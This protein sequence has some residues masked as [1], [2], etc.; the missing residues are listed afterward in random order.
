MGSSP[1]RNGFSPRMSEM[2]FNHSSTR[3]KV[4]SSHVKLSHFWNY[5]RRTYPFVIHS[6]SLRWYDTS[7]LHPK[8]SVS[9]AWKSTQL[10][11]DQLWRRLRSLM[12]RL[13][14][15][16]DNLWSPPPSP[17]TPCVGG[18][19]GLSELRWCLLARMRYAS[20]L[21]QNGEVD[22]CGSWA[23]AWTGEGS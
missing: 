14:S 3:P 13:H 16:K 4:I 7:S 11:L 8:Y 20:T 19:W 1:K 17:Y 2:R 6:D 12:L 18:E 5:A 9:N 23:L 21:T 15:V 10:N 22:T